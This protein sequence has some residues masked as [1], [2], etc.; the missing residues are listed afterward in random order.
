[1][2]SSGT[3]FSQLMSLVSKY[4][5]NCCV[6]RYTSNP[7][8]RKFSY[9]DQFLA[10]SFAQLTFRESLRD[11]EI[12]LS[13]LG[14]RTYQ[15][16]FRSKV[17]R[18]TLADANNNRDWRIWSEFASVLTKQAQQLYA[19]E[20]F[21]FP[22]ANSA[23]VLD[24]TVITLCLS[25][26]PW[27]K[28]QIS[29][30]AIKLHTQL[31]LR[32]SIP[33]FCL[34][35]KG[36][37]G[38]LKFLDEIA[39]E[40]GALYVMDRAYFD[41]SRLYQFTLQGSFFVTRLRG[42]LPYKRVEIFSRDR[43][44]TI[45][46]DAA[47]KFISVKA[48]RHYPD[49]MRLVEYFDSENSRTFTFLTNNFSLSAQTIA[50][51]Y[52]SRWRVELFF[53]WIKQHLRIKAFFGLSEN[54]VKTQIWIAISV[55]LLIA[56]LRKQVAPKLSLYSV[57]QVLSVSSTK[58]IPIFQAFQQNHTNSDMTEETNQMNLFD[59]TTGQ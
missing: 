26:F 15:M 38:D 25:L 34:I 20:E 50:D 19:N 42:K 14:E 18:S 5:F 3:I 1:M 11:I 24:S 37:M 33:S 16:G 41:Y 12:C 45:R 44:G 17:R 23:Y 21:D 47:I 48:K 29:Q 10:M 32:G 9:W 22:F 4:E 2:N 57:L 52:K 27:A 46:F 6:K 56:I 53:K 31:S 13:A 40:P 28:Y 51:V 30:R 59:F 49:R 36:K 43:Y 54:A 8:P 55:Y 35:S 7:I 58:K 39:I